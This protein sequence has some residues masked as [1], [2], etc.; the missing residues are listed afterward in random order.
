VL[1]GDVDVVTARRTLWEQHRL[2]V[3][4]G[5]ASVVAALRS[6]AYVPERGE[7]VAAVLCGA[8]TAPD[9]LTPEAPR[10]R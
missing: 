5:A 8:N 4:H 3:E 7:R 2:V 10:P 9:D 1:V 6:G